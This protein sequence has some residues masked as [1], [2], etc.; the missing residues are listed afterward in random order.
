MLQD[1]LSST[2]LKF[3][4]SIHLFRFTHFTA[5]DG[6]KLQCLDIPILSDS[7]CHNSYP[8]MIDSSMFCAGYLEGGK[9]SC[10]VCT[11]TAPFEVSS[12]I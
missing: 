2:L 9:D 3:L 11:Y 1:R 12:F 10:Q 5:A 4:I 7:D 8:G 6:D